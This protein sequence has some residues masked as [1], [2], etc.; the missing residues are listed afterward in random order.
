MAKTNKKRRQASSY[1]PKDDSVHGETLRRKDYWSI[2][3]AARVLNCKPAVVSRLAECGCFGPT[4]RYE[5][6]YRLRLV[7]RERVESFQRFTPLERAAVIPC[8]VDNLEWPDEL[9]V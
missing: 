8:E 7:A 2:T 6:D 4:Y 3:E 5:G 9:A 1:Y